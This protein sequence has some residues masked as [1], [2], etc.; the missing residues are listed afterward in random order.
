M[1]GNLAEGAIWEKREPGRDDWVDVSFSYYSCSNII[2]II[3]RM[4]DSNAYSRVESPTHH[5]MSVDIVI[6]EVEERPRAD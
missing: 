2:L 4:E 6:E 1:E 3:L 5:K